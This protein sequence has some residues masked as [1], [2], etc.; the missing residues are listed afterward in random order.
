MRVQL[1]GLEV[2]LGE[3]R[4][5]CSSS[6]QNASA[7]VVTVITVLEDRAATLVS[8]YLANLSGETAASHMRL[9]PGQRPA[10]TQRVLAGLPGQSHPRACLLDHAAELRTMLG[11]LAENDRVAVVDVED[12]A[13]FLA[14]RVFTQAPK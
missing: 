4:E 12:R 3:R 6:I 10:F 13:L 2:R 14:S 9:S 5:R 11:E 8:T 7:Y 1:E